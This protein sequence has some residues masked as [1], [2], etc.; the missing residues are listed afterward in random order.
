M[1]RTEGIWKEEQINTKK[2]LLSGGSIFLS[3]KTGQNEC[4]LLNV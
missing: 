2:V 4:H 3:K 1:G